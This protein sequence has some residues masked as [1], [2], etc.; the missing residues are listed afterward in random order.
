MIVSNSESDEKRFMTLQVLVRG[1]PYRE[2]RPRGGQ[3]KLGIIFRGTGI[4]ITDAERD[5][6]HPDVIVRFQPKAWADRAYSA[7]WAE[8]DWADYILNSGECNVRENYLLFHDNLDSQ[9]TPE[10][11]AAL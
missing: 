3:P 10:F 9:T 11:R 5:L 4:R 7:A 2:G 8:E 6:Y 1:I